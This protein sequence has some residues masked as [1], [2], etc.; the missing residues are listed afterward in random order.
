MNRKHPRTNHNIGPEN[1]GEK[2]ET[3]PAKKKSQTA[4]ILQDTQSFKNLILRRAKPS[5]IQLIK[6]HYMYTDLHPPLKPYQLSRAPNENPNKRHATRSRRNYVDHETTSIT[7]PYQPKPF[8][9]YSGG[10]RR[11]GKTRSP[12]RAGLTFMTWSPVI[13]ELSRFIY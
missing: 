11:N 5:Q 9:G 12:G 10:V 13:S 4:N 1:K 6:I 3:T 7:S 8:H 2:T